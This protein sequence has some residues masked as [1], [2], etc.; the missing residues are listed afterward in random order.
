MAGRPRGRP[1]K[2][3]TDEQR[4]AGRAAVLK[5]KY[6]R[7]VIP[8]LRQYEPD[9]VILTKLK[10]DILLALLQKQK[11]YNLQFYKIAAQIH[12]TT[13][14]PHLDILLLYK[15]TVRK[16]LNRF[17]YLIKHGH[18]S[19]YKKLNE[20]I[21]SYGDKEDL[22][23]KT[24]FPKDLSWILKVNQMQLD[25]YQLLQ[26]EMLKDPFNFEPYQWLRDHNLYQAISK[27]NW[28]K[29][30][31][32]LNKRRQAQC[33]NI[34]HDK[35]GFLPIDKKH[36]KQCLSIRQYAKF[37]K[38]LT[39]YKVI[40]SKINEVLVY[41]FDR[42]HKTKNLLIVGPPNTGKTSLALQIQKHVSVYYMGVHNWFPSYRNRIYKMILWNQFN[43]KC[44]AY[45]QL[46]NFLEGTKI[47]LQYKGGSTLKTDNQLI[48]M[49]SNM[50]LSQH[51][52][53]RFSSEDSRALA[54]A[55]LRARI[56]QVILPE[57]I[58]LFLLQKLITSAKN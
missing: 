27:T 8:N 1:R 6:F 30:I 53:S 5:G 52:A 35:P 36:A 22:D 18:L 21:L 56:E 37:L 13:G 51:I 24:N 26:R 16:S 3:A 34:L 10:E 50:T 29:V 32:L 44:M 40:L 38:H 58:D 12:P 19:K 11:S 7:L 57:G 49:T 14:I 9:S 55:N 15:R 2:H 48:F 28:S 47:D 41:G 17:D 54:E 42:P 33:N 4:K 20:A 39:N 23:P 31:S 46:L 25:P 43:L 45:P